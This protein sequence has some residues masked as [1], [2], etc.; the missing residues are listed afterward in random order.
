MCHTQKGTEIQH[1]LIHGITT[2]VRGK[3]YDP[4]H[5]LETFIITF[6]S[7]LKHPV[8]QKVHA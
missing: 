2:N 4:S 8:I 7:V 5:Y 1:T 3:R 6:I